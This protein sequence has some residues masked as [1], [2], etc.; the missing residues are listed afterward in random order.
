MYVCMY[1][2]TYFAHHGNIK[3]VLTLVYSIKR[4]RKTIMYETLEFSGHQWQVIPIYNLISNYFNEKQI[5]IFKIFFY[6][7]ITLTLYQFTE[8]S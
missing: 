6:I 5:I 8:I 4:C 2:L 1:P 7:Q 3:P